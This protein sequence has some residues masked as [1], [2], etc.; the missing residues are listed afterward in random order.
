[1]ARQAPAWWQSRGAVACLW[2]PVSALFF[3]VAT[4]RRLAYRV[5][6]FRAWRLPVPVIVVGNIAVGGSGKTPVV[7]WLVQALR[8]RGLRPA[9]LSRGYGGSAAK[10]PRAV[11]PDSD[12]GEVGDEPVLLA[13]R[14]QCPVFV[15]PDRV[16]GGRALLK[17]HPD[18]DVVITDDGLQHY[19]LQRD[20]EIIV[21]DPATLGNRWLL[22]AG[23]LR[24]PL[25]R[26]G[27]AQLLLWH[28]RP[29]ATVTQALRARH[30]TPDIQ[31]MRLQPGDFYRLDAPHERRDAASLQGLR[32]RAVAGIGQ[33]QRFFDTLRAL[34]L[35]PAR[36]DAFPDHH[37]YV[38]ADLDLQACDVLLMTEKDAIKCAGLAPPPTWVLPVEALI[39][40]AA[41]APVLERVHGSQ[42][43]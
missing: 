22:P 37:A 42:T 40:D 9:I 38:A 4:L 14:A 29:D 21:L 24:E 11:M 30:G 19:R 10:T 34:G 17:R 28:G 18:V 2:L 39:A 20:V 13:R 27:E 16:A 25:S 8:R 23:P 7:I 43:A 6:I 32:L 5:G 33:P 1:M 12:P 26:A 3:V 41:L 31:P 36:T 15:S 35:E